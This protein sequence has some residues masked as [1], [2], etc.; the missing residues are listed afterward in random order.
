MQAKL[1]W[2]NVKVACAGG[3]A[4][5]LILCVMSHVRPFVTAALF[6]YKASLS[7][8][9]HFLLSYSNDKNT[10]LSKTLYS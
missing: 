9:L 2:L 1:H 7:D 5:F 6:L 10:A 4:L 8:P 3:K